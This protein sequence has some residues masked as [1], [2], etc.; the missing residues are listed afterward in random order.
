MQ[1]VRTPSLRRRGLHHHLARRLQATRMES[2]R[3][4]VCRS[5]DSMSPLPATR[6]PSAGSIIRLPSGVT[7]QPAD[8]L[9]SSRRRRGRIFLTQP[10]EHPPG[11]SNSWLS[12]YSK[13]SPLVPP[14]DSAHGR[15]LPASSQAAA[16]PAVS[17]P[18]QHTMSISNVAC[19]LS[20]TRFSTSARNRWRDRFGVIG[21]G[22]TV[23]RRPLPHHRAYGSVHGGSRRLR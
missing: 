18:P 6:L 4:V 22:A 16:L 17:G 2:Q 8:T 14:L 11:E 21:I 3:A 5:V 20:T 1:L 13:T 19:S 9:P 23:T 15:F 10:V 7:R 12:L